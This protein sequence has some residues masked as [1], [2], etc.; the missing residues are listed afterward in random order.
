MFFWRTKK[1]FSELANHVL[2]LK[3]LK[4]RET[5][6]AAT[7]QIARLIKNFGD[8]PVEEL[9][10]KH[11]VDYVAR[12]R[13]RKER[14][15]YDDKK[16]MRMILRYA[17]A[18]GALERTIQLPIPDLPSDVGREITA[19]ELARLESCAG[20]ELLFQIRIA[21]K[22]GLRLREMLRLRWDQ[23]DWVNGTIKLSPGDTKTRRGRV[24]PMPPDLMPQF[25]ARRAEN[26][27]LCHKRGLGL[28]PFVFPC[29]RR[30]ERR[31]KPQGENKTAWRACKAEAGVKARWH[32]LRHTCAT[33][34][35]RSGIRPGVVSKMLGMSEQVLRR[36]YEHQNLDDLREAARA[37][38][39]G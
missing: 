39:G 26:G 33:R 32:D 20:P 21:W 14:K 23:F 10:E 8:I 16:Y 22:M 2:H 29:H 18:V 4:S 28:S 34:L 7:R 9:T 5:R 13:A 6:L 35:L 27:A 17:L 11:W 36:I 31:F 30:R 1:K 19:D 24:V 3:Q 38:A 12:E 37:M 15:F 25:N